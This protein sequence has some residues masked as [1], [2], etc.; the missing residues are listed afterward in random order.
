MSPTFAQAMDGPLGPI[1]PPPPGGA[2][3]PKK[4]SQGPAPSPLG[5]M[6]T[7]ARMHARSRGDD[8]KEEE[9][10]EEEGDKKAGG[11][12]RQRAACHHHPLLL[13]L[14]VAGAGM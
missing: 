14:R 10:K 13:V 6:E 12:R 1:T 5:L 9:K 2:A 4:G 3:A 8:D 7:A 11:K